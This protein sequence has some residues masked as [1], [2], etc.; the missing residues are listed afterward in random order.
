MDASKIKVSREDMAVIKPEQLGLSPFGVLS[1]LF[2][3]ELEQRIRL[4]TG[5]YAPLPL[6]LREEDEEPDA[7]P[8]VEVELSVDIHMDA[9]KAAPARKEPEKKSGVREAALETR[10]LE[11]VRIKERE[12]QKKQ[13]VLHKL[14]IRLEEGRWTQPPTAGGQSQSVAAQPLTL[15]TRAAAVPSAGGWAPQT[16]PAH[17]GYPAPKSQEDGQAAGGSILLPDVLRRRREQALQWQAQP[18]LEWLHQSELSPDT[19][20]QM[21]HAVHQAVEQTLALNHAKN[22]VL[23]GRPRTEPP[24]APARKP[25]SWRDAAEP[26]APEQ[27]A[28]GQAVPMDGPFAQDPALT[29][30]ARLS[31]EPHLPYNSQNAEKGAHPSRRPGPE[32]SSNSRDASEAGGMER[33]ATSAKEQGQ[34]WPAENTQASQSPALQEREPHKA[35]QVSELQEKESH[36]S[37]QAAEPQ[38]QAA[39]P[40]AVTQALPAESTQAPALMQE[41]LIYRENEAETARPADHKAPAQATGETTH[42]NQATHAR[43]SAQAENNTNRPIRTNYA[44]P[45]AQAE[46][47]INHPSRTT[48]E[49]SSAQAENNTDR[50]AGR[51]PAAQ[52][53][54]ESSRVVEALEM[55][56]R[57]PLKAMRVSDLQEQDPH[58]ASQSPALQEREPH[59]AMQVSELQEKESHGSV[60]AAEPQEQAAGP[61]AV[62]QA[63]PVESTQAPAPIQEPLIYRENEAETAHLAERPT[64]AQAPSEIARPAQA[65]HARSSAQAENNTN[66]PIQ[67]NYAQSSAQTEIGTNHPAWTTHE[68][69]S[70]QAEKDTDR[71]AGRHPAAQTGQESHRV[72]QSPVLQEREPLKAMQGS[73]LQGQDSSGPV[74]SL[75]PQEQATGHDAVPQALP[76]ES[77]QA[78]APMQEPLIYRESEA[79]TARPA[80]RQTSAQTPSEIAR[81][82]QTTRAQSSAQAENNTNRLIQ[83]NY[84]HLSAQ[85][86]TGTNHPARTTYEQSSVQAEKD[87]D[88]PAGWHPAVQIGQESHGAVQA[89]KL[90]EQATGHD[91]VPQ[92]LPAE[93]AQVPAPM[94]EPLIYRE[95]EAETARPADH[96]A[97][98]QTVREATHPAQTTRTRS[99][100]QAE[101]NTNRLIQTDYAQS[102]AQAENNTGRTDRE[103]GQAAAA[104]MLPPAM[105]R[106]AWAAEQLVYRAQEAAGQT[107]AQ[108]PLSALP[109]QDKSVASSAR[110]IALTLHRGAVQSGN[111]AARDIR[112]VHPVP[113]A[114]DGVPGQ[115]Q[116]PQLVL[117]G[118]GSPELSRSDRP[119]QARGME[120]LPDWARELL[121]KG[122]LPKGPRPA[123]AGPR[124]FQ[125]TSPQ[126][127]A[128]PGGTVQTV[129]PQGQAA[130]SAAPPQLSNAAQVPPSL[131]HPQKN[132]EEQSARQKAE[133]EAEI[134]RTADRVYRIIEERL[135][136]ELRRSG[137]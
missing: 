135:R 21:M 18:Q 91:A 53:G 43:S 136:R 77:T 27:P 15:A 105:A 118:G 111:P 13:E 116:P 41:P 112:L 56:D 67:T 58:R 40:D 24:A 68:Q 62:P 70:A 119:E 126:A 90:Q 4:E 97:P 35:M 123:Q 120:A 113:A 130:Q 117:A 55:Q 17:P 107:P 57:E 5:A 63:L 45:S 134:R 104:Q 88:R 85:A 99:S 12:L 72:S 34:A 82:A 78:P 20:R 115:E 109:A 49:Q 9:P 121:E 84:A 54:K 80:E 10:I 87:T 108:N 73:E 32:P 29:H 83:T 59:K 47:G 106:A 11:K 7:A 76:A 23:S 33:R 101:N 39:G 37:V 28:A 48:Y 3:Q 129:L 103:E 61:E 89:A 131:I 122:P 92:A 102:S 25:L 44:H 42:P 16:L 52:A 2:Q 60:Q 66:R 127:M 19:A 46:T 50:P 110:P 114:G 71:P 125:W 137:R 128:A 26:S 8:P 96:K 94:Q 81:P 1:S 51:H 65:T 30:K 100:A 93:S 74:Q 22:P 69:S 31:Q 36:G 133:R 64:S 98:A 124:Q 75:E 132:E 38:E 86:E 95:S 6:T 14:E 79:E